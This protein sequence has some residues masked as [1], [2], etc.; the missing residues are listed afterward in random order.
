[1]KGFIQYIYIYTIR[2]I[3]AVIVYFSINTII[4]KNKL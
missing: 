2:V 1:M 4:I 3:K